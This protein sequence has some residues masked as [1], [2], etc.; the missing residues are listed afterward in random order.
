MGSANE[1]VQRA[2]FIGKP[3]QADLLA[4]GSGL[5]LIESNYTH[6]IAAAYDFNET[7]FSAF[8]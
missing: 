7:C 6:P 8:G 4:G 1:A 3:D 5:R 2:M